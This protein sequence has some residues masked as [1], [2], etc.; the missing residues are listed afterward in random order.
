MLI[1][2]TSNIWSSSSLPLTPLCMK[3]MKLST[4]W[5]ASNSYKIFFF[6]ALSQNDT[7]NNEPW[8]W[9]GGTLWSGVECTQSCWRETSQNV[10]KTTR[11]K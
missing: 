1:G 3:F 11:S 9:F 6:V 10:T 5:M 2:W 4:L 8:R 7:E